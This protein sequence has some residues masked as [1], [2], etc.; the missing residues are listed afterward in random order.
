MKDVSF[1]D[2]ILSF[3]VL[4]LFSPSALCIYYL[5]YRWYRGFD[6]ANFVKLRELAKR[7]EERR[8]KREEEKR[9]RRLKKIMGKVRK[10]SPK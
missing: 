3:L 2:S 10:K 5:F 9:R 7:K 1:F 6:Q 4:V 8:Q